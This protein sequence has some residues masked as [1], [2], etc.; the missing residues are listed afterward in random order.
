M[1]IF[2][3]EM[4]FN[5]QG[6]HTPEEIAAHE[7]KQRG[8]VHRMVQAATQMAMQ[9]QQ[10]QETG[11]YVGGQVQDNE[12]K[13]KG[14]ASTMTEAERE[15]L[16]YELKIKSARLE[17]KAREIQAQA[18]AQHESDMRFIREAYGGPSL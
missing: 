4:N 5:L 1:G 12:R 3:D 18:K 6:S 13:S 8:N 14:A 10:A 15:K 9:R 16:A 11:A 2:T 17:E 7:Q